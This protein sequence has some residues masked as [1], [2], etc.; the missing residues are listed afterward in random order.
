MI[1][2]SQGKDMTVCGYSGGRVFL[3]SSQME[4]R[5]L[6]DAKRF[7]QH[8]QVQ[9]P[10]PGACDPLPLHAPPP[11]PLCGPDVDGE[12]EAQRC[13]HSPRPPWEWSQPPPRSLPFPCV[14]SLGDFLTGRKQQQL[15]SQVGGQSCRPGF[16][17]ANSTRLQ[18]PAAAWEVCWAAACRTLSVLRGRTT[19]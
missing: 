3:T 6:R 18:P 9:S 10:Q 19:C 13:Y 12:T 17:S 16:Q 15:F 7:T 8:P 1:G 11:P 2:V 14:A 5:R 4:K